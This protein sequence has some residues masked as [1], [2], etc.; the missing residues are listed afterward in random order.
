M[1]DP[2]ALFLQSQRDQEEQNELLPPLE[3]EGFGG[4]ISDIGAI[5]TGDGQGQGPATRS[6]PSLASLAFTVELYWS[7]EVYRGFFKDFTVV[8]SAEKLG[9]FDYTITFRVTQRRG[10]RQNFLGWHRS[11][12]N[13]PSNSNSITGTPHSFGAL[14]KGS[15]TP[16]QNN[17]DQ[18]NLFSTAAGTFQNIL[19]TGG[20]VV[21]LLTAFDV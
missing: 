10:F 1:F 14:S 12:I 11:A 9:F 13:G 18:P 8:E 2:Y 16:Q 3:D 17:V 15:V 6:R 21:G 7:G 4:L 19:E 20:D 5:L